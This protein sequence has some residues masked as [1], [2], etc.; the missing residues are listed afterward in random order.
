MLEQGAHPS[1]F[2]YLTVPANTIDINIHPTKTEIKFDNEKALY[3]M[4]R[5]TVKHSLGQYNVAPVLDFNRDAGLDTP[6][7]FKGGSTS[8][9]VPKI[10]VDPDFNPFKEEQQKAISFPFK[11]EKETQSWESLYTSVNTTDAQQNESLFEHQQE[12]KTQK[13]FQIQRKYVLSL[14]KSGVVLINQSLAHQR[15]LYEEFLESITIREANSQQLL[16]P[17]KISFSSFL[18]S[19]KP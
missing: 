12:E 4:L 6:Y 14:I 17:V 11:R 3:A 9:S 10:S 2:L 8:G 18:F 19:L 15:V 5:A 7:H 13:T 16:F 1:Y